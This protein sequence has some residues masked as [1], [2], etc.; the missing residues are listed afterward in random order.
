[1]PPPAPPRPRPPAQQQQPELDP[2]RLV[3]LDRDATLA[4]LGQPSSVR[5]QPPS[6]VWTY[7]TQGCALD[8]FFF[9]D[10]STRAFRVLST[11]LSIDSRA[12][13]A[14]RNCLRQLQ[15]NSRGH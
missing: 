11:E 14:R 2:R 5:E 6:T 1:V 10:L 15:A 13:D 12:A 9:M 4:M 8:I 3:G 7:K